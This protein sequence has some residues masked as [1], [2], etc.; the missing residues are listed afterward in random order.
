MKIFLTVSFLLLNLVG[1]AQKTIDV[2]K[3]TGIPQNS[4]YS[5]G[6]EPFVNAKFI[7]LTSG[8]PYF[9]DEWMKGIGVSGTGVVYRAGIL[10]LDLFDHKV[11]FLDAGGN[12][13]ITTSP[14]QQ[15]TL[16]DSITGKSYHFVHSSLFA[17]PT[18]KQGWY[19]Q[20]AAGKISLYQFFSKIISEN[21]PYG[22]ATTEQSIIT[23]DE[24]FVYYNAA[25]H[26]VK[27]VKD[28]PAILI[29]YKKDMED[30]LNKN[31]KT[32][33]LADQLTASVNFYNNLQ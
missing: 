24:F 5:V 1:I 3:T 10:K 23:K 31:S 14:L 33:S 4:F 7:R 28:L 15:V 25:L 19:L 9:K 20:L 17:L 27:K 6:G 8:T 30:F 18:M 11:H 32:G 22:S 16:T 21:R 26:Q 12:E 2:E 13:M 29:D